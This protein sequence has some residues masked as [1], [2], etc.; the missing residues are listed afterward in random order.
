MNEV[1]TVNAL[2]T[3]PYVKA[4]VAAL[5]HGASARTKHA[6]DTIRAKSKGVASVTPSGGGARGNR[7]VNRRPRAGAKMSGTL[8]RHCGTPAVP[9]SLLKSGA[10]EVIDAHGEWLCE[11]DRNFEAFRIPHLRSAADVH[12]GPHDMRE[13]MVF[14]D[15]THKS[16]NSHDLVHMAAMRRNKAYKG[17]YVMPSTAMFR[18]FVDKLIDG[19]DVRD[20]VTKGKAAAISPCGQG[21]Y[22][23]RLESGRVVRTKRVVC[24]LG[25]NLRRDKMFWESELGTPGIDF[26]KDAIA[27]AS[28]L[29]EWLLRFA[30][31]TTA[32]G[33]QTHRPRVTIVGGGLTS[34]HV[35][36]VL[37]ECGCDQ[38]TLLVRSE[39]RTQQ[40]DL[41]KRWFGPGRGDLLGA[42]HSA[43]VPTRFEMIQRARG[44]GGSLS[45]EARTML[46]EA[47]DTLTTLCGV[48]VSS[49]RWH[50]P[51]QGPPTA[52][53]GHWAVQLDDATPP[54]VSDVLLLA[55]GA[56]IDVEQYP[57]LESLRAHTPVDVYNGL[58][59]L[60]PDLRWAPGENVFLM[61]TIAALELGPDALN[62]AGAR[63]AACRIARTLRPEL[64][65]VAP[66]KCCAQSD[67]RGM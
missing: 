16:L 52:A 27:H 2:G 57:F 13:L 41:D 33:P 37:R 51:D 61:G 42:F 18:E 64:A 46:D 55:T 19:Y 25:P 65:Q 59:V 47:G 48:E 23:V 15:L 3:W 22:A 32:M 5:T 50:A 10:I 56:D 26:P 60:Q 9:A 8:P 39:L 31:R 35:V 67:T 49:V 11:W 58:P 40:F 6:V 28:G 62:L 38:I 34:A 20:S 1:A 14:A 45:P 21:H 53:G 43:D 36:R 17:P 63:H 4:R 66:P 30:G 54:I 7:C 44:G 29:F 24:A 12:P